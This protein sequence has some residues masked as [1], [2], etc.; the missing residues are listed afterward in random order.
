MDFINTD[1]QMC[2]KVVN[3]TDKR[4]SDKEKKKIDWMIQQNAVRGIY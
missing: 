3:R 2:H 1:I 4:N